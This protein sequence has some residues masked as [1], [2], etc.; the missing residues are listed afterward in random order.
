M[1]SAVQQAGGAQWVH[2]FARWLV[3]TVHA[4]GVHF[5][6]ICGTEPKLRSLSL[7]S[8]AEVLERL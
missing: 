1:D 7:S 4:A 2:F 5:A 6:G 8:S 3:Q